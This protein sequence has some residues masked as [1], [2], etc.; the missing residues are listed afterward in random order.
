MRLLFICGRPFTDFFFLWIHDLQIE[1][2]CAPRLDG[3]W[4]LHSFLYL[5]A[6]YTFLQGD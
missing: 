1:N 3:F 2:I 4:F 6:I 5:Q